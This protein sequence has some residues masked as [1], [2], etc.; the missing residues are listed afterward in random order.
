MPP[1]M[2]L[3][4]CY[5]D[6]KKKGLPPNIKN[7]FDKKLAPPTLAY[8]WIST[9]NFIAINNYSAVFVEW[10]MIRDVYSSFL[11]KLTQ[12]NPWLPLIILSGDTT[13]EDGLFV[14]N[15]HLF[16]LM[17]TE[18]IETGGPDIIER[19]SVYHE[20]AGN[21][22]PDIK[23]MLRPNGFG[24]FIGNSLPMLEIYRQLAK[25]AKTD[26]SVL[27]LGESGSGKELVAKTIHNLSHRNKKAFVSIN[28]AAIPEQLLESELF[29]YDKGA[30]TGAD[31]TKP[32]KFEV[33]NGGTL[34]LDEIGDMAVGLQAKLLRVL[35]EKTIE[36]LG[37]NATKSIDIRVLAATNQDLTDLIEEKKFRADL[38][39]RLNVIQLKIA[40]LLNRQNDVV[41]LAI[42]L[43]SRLQKHSPNPNLSVDWDFME[44]LRQH[45]ISGNVRELENLLTRVVFHAVESK[46]DRRNLLQVIRESGPSQAVTDKTQPV[47]PLWQLEKKALQNAIDMF[48][49]NITRIAE[50]LEIS[51]PAIYRKLKKYKLSIPDGDATS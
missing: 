38:N 19:I 28:C 24:D 51:R 47:E 48:D 1:K 25:V 37:Q 13:L 43:L 26:Y 29:G 35:E 9:L 6:L 40:P 12:L 34:F 21:F 23:K 10:S 50:G 45:N 22:E 4:I 39:Y 15:Q 31:H 2:K 49:G 32:G 20:I 30:F 8:N 17:R 18:N 42:Y 7:F 3:L 11:E 46:L 33:A 16:A 14:P 36:P 5:P 27:I 41:L 44:E